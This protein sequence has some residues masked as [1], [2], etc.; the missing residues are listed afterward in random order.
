MVFSLSQTHTLFVRRVGEE[1]L[2]LHKGSSSVSR[3]LI[4]AQRDP[5]GTKP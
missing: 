4:C 1:P 5:G 2:L 3:R